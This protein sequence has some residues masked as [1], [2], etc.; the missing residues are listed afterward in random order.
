MPG[1]RG[2]VAFVAL[3]HEH[4]DATDSLRVFDLPTFIIGGDAVSCGS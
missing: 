1:P 3:E 4:S 2:V